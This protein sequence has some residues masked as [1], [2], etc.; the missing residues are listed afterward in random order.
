[1]RQLQIL[2]I[3]SAMGTGV[4]VLPQRVAAYLPEGVQDGWVIAVGLMIVAIIVGALISAAARAAQRAAE[5]ELGR[6]EPS[7]IES[8][9]LLLTKPVAYTVGFVMWVKL[10]IAAGLEL[11]IFLEISREIMLPKTPMWVIAAVMIAACAYAASKGMETRAQIAEVLFA[12]MILPFL[13][14]FIVAIMDADFS[15]LKPALVTDAR[16]LVLGTVRLGFILTG[17]ECLLLVSPYVPREKSLARA[18]AG[19]LGIAGLIIAAITAITI[20]SLGR[21]VASEPWPVLRMMDV[22]NISFIQR[23]EALMF[24]FWIITAFVLGNAMLFFGGLLVRDVFKKPSLGFGVTVSAIAVFCVS[25]IPFSREEIFARIDTMYITTGVFFLVVFPLIIL[26]ASKI[27]IAGNKKMLL[28]LPFALLLVGCWDKVEIEDRAFVVAIGIDKQDENYIVMVSIPATHNEE[29]DEKQYA[30]MKYAEGRTVTE[31]LK[32]L[33]ENSDKELYYSQTKLLIIGTN[34]TE[35]REFL[36]NA[37]ET[38]QNTLKSP[39]RINVLAAENPSEILEVKPPREIYRNTFEFDFEKL[40]AQTD[41]IIPKIEHDNDELKLSGAVLIKNHEKTGT[42]DEMQSF[43]WCVTDGNN[44]KVVTADKPKISMEVESHKAQINF[45]QTASGIR[46]II[47]VEVHGTV[48]EE[49]CA[50][51]QAIFAQKISDEISETAKKLQ[52]HNIDAYD[53]VENLRKNNYT[54]YTKHTDEKQEI[55]S[56]MEIVPRV[57]VSLQ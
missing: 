52:Q 8:V 28:L 16:A 37:I 50:N 15:N 39:R 32:Y 38:L 4:I 33:D 51:T 45:E 25:I 3:L 1:M 55:F 5:L 30:Q 7:F 11:R 21:G 46:A 34:L 9:A 12:L 47:N 43:L 41:M 26:T 13:F 18:V 20:A 44:E 49:A 17:L 29:E 56:K 19:A 10:V 31:A 22:A 23:Q 40:S 42:L 53:M 14:L 24:G 57:M 35:D 2:I 48:Y 6:E 54:L 27:S 36:R